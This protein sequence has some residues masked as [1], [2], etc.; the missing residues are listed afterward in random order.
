MP[1]IGAGRPIDPSGTGE[2]GRVLFDDLEGL[3]LF[4]SLIVLEQCKR[5]AGVDAGAGEASVGGW[6]LG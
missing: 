4:D 1:W 3:I 5:I 6:G 2:I